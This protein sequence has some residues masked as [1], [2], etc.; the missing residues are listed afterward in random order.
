MPDFGLEVKRVGDHYELY[1][2]HSGK[3]IASC[4]DDR[5]L[6]KEIKEWEEKNLTY[7]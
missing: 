3:F 4:D 2:S 6:Q 7:Q 1:E 5:E